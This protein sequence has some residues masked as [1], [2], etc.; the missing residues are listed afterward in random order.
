M[1]V[2]GI[3]KRYNQRKLMNGEMI[4]ALIN[5]PECGKQISSQA[6]SC[7]NCGCPITSRPTS[8]KI[9][10]LSDDRHVKR[11]KFAIGGRVVAEAP[12]GSVATI[13]IN[14]P[15]TID[16]TIVLGFIGGGSP[17]RFCAI[18]GKC[19]EARYCKPGLAFWETQVREV[20]I[21]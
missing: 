2:N 13:T 9:R 5:C 10:C 12:L 6:A 8:V 19:Y 17:A 1:V 21:V 3:E 7:P 11:M 18:P 20:S 16:V 4:M 15:T 14:E